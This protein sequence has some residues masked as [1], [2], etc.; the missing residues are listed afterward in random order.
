MHVVVRVAV[1]ALTVSALSTQAADK[2][3]ES[4]LRWGLNYCSKVL[5]ELELSHGRGDS[6]Q[7]LNGVVAKCEPDFQKF[8]D[9]VAKATAIDP[10]VTSSD[11]VFDKKTGKTYG[12]LYT[13][14]QAV[15][16]QLDALRQQAA[17]AEATRVAAKDQERKDF[18]AGVAHDKALGLVR[19]AVHDVC[20]LI[21]GYAGSSG[22]DERVAAYEKAK[23]EALAALPAIADE[24]YTTSITRPGDQTEELTKPVKDWFA[25]CDTYIPETLGALRA[26]EASALAAEKAE[27]ERRAAM[28]DKLRAEAKAK[29][30]ALVAATTGDRQRILKAHGWLP[31]WPRGG[32]LGG[33]PVW[34]W[35][36]NITHEAVRCESF[37]F[38]G[39]KLTKNFTSLGACP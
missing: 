26:K 24:P 32:D 21:G 6:P 23:A 27:S 1:V 34:K 3:A 31:S 16:A 20:G 39:S 11:T 36:I 22:L 10:A 35:E 14:C 25:Y 37:Q 5:K 9:Y 2:K 17:G 18:E 13:E 12:Q 29:F 38:S 15:P 33:A 30:N 4:E 7:R 28:D 8:Q 19:D